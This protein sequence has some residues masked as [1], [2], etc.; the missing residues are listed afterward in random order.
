MQVV[1]LLQQQGLL[2]IFL[3]QRLPT[4]RERHYLTQAQALIAHCNLTNAQYDVNNSTN[5]M[6]SPA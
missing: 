2:V 6:L 1:A 4:Q 5:I 3:I